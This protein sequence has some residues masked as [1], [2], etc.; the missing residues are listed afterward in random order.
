MNALCCLMAGFSLLLSVVTV[1]VAA[2][3]INGTS[4]YLSV[5]NNPSLNISNAMTIKTGAKANINWDAHTNRGRGILSSG[6]YGESR[7]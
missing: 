3:A 2:L 5:P 7:G 6:R 4:N 1:P